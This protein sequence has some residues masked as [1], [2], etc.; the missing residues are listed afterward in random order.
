MRKEYYILIGILVTI[1]VGVSLVVIFFKPEIKTM[2]INEI[3]RPKYLSK[4]KWEKKINDDVLKALAD[5]NF[6]KIKEISK[7]QLKGD[8]PFVTRI[9]DVIVIM[10]YEE[11]VDIGM[12]AITHARILNTKLPENSKLIVLFG[13][14]D[15]EP[16]RLV[17][18]N[19]MAVYTVPVKDYKKPWRIIQNE[20]LYEV[21]SLM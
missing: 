5:S 18:K 13:Y 15:K 9:E 3:E 20:V 19:N 10:R 1:I 21:S 11:H 6:N 8:E 7:K 4:L 16:K 2:D 17:G 12:E 14:E